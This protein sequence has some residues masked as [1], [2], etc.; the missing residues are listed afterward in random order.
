[1]DEAD[2]R[3]LAISARMEGLS[4]IA[5]NIGKKRKVSEMELIALCTFAEIGMLHVFELTGATE[6]AA[7]ADDIRSIIEGIRSRFG[8]S[9]GLPNFVNC[10][11]ATLRNPR[12]S[13]YIVRETS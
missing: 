10:V 12:F 7:A 4:A 9:G 3:H 1:M 5:R 2:R 6:T 11:G 13:R 8:E